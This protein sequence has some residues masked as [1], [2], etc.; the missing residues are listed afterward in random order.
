MR[1]WNARNEKSISFHEL[2]KGMAN[3]I[4][5]STNPDGF[6]HARISQL[7]TAETTIEHLKLRQILR[8]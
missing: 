5:S 8:L 6:H 4:A 3:R 7:S 2:M 1:G